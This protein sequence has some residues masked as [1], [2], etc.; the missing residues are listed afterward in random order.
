MLVGSALLAASEAAAQ[1]NLFTSPIDI[2]GLKVLVVAS[3]PDRNTGNPVEVPLP[4]GLLGPKMNQFM[5]TPLSSQVDRYWNIIPDPKTGKTPRDQACNGPKGIIKQ[6]QDNVHK[7]GSSFNAYDISCNLATTGSLLLKQVGPEQYIGYLL[8]NNRVDFW[9]TTPGTCKPGHGTPV[10]P[11][12]P[13]LVVTFAALLTT[14]IRTPDVCHIVAENGTVT[15][16]GVTIDSANLA[17]DVAKLADDLVLGHKFSAAERSIEA[18][19]TGVTLPLDSNFKELRDSDGC[20]GK[21][22]SIRR[23]LVA[24]R[25]F[26]VTVQPSRGLLFRMAHPGITAPTVSAPDANAS[27]APNQ[28]TF[29]RPM[30]STNRP[31]AAAGSS[32]QVSGQNFPLNVN[33]ST[34][35]PVT[36]GHGGYGAGSIVL[37]GVCFA[38]ATELQWGPVGGPARLERLAGD[39][40]GACA[41]R[42]DAPNLSPGATYQF[43]ARDC[44]AVTCSPWSPQTRA[45]TARANAASGAVTLTMDGASGPTM[46][47]KMSASSGRVA[48][49]HSPA[50]AGGGPSAPAISA[51]RKVGTASNAAAVVA[52]ANSNLGSATVTAQG[53]FVANV[54]IPASVSPGAHTIRAVDGSAVA[55]VGVTVSGTNAGGGAASLMIVGLLHGETGCPNHPITSTATGSPFMLFGAGMDPGSAAVH[56]DAPNGPILGTANARP[57]GTFCQQMPGVPGNQA[58][59]HRLLAVQNGVVKAQ[60]AVTF[61]TPSIVH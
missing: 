44:D 33:L 15:T 49:G 41:S 14:L 16:Q 55:V 38:G 27:H 59:N 2:T 51:A 60:T 54:T 45:T 30:I 53:T 26:D 31:V 7:I 24:F 5:S 9:V 20:T 48:A 28:P 57:D 3:A 19:E 23:M 18:V 36:L 13:H 37:G 61:V 50:P 8:K 58:G 1:P 47:D 42:F 52:A 10:C 39:A 17:A 43:R 12:D 4:L 29:T 21:N 56:L 46:A 40:Q 35:L 6:V 11:N 34:A 32:L 22:S 25:N